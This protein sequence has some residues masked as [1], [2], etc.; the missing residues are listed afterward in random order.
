MLIETPR[1]LANAGEE[2]TE[3]DIANKK[4]FIRMPLN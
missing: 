3:I 2:M 4:Y 1:S